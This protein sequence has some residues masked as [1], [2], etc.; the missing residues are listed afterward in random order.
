MKGIVT[1]VTLAFA[2]TVAAC[3]PMAS[4]EPPM[5]SLAAPPTPPPQTYVIT[6]GDSLAIKFYKN[7]ELN[8]DAIVRPDG[9]IS[10]QL[11]DDVPAA[12]R[13]TAQLAADLKQRYA[14]ELAD[15]AIAVIVRNLVGNRVYIGGEV[16]KQGSIPLV[17]G[18]TVFQAIQEAGGFARTAHR[19]QV[20]LIR[21]TPDGKATGRAIDVRPRPTAD[22]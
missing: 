21:R 5:P 18:M 20:I 3:R 15:P 13:T 1:I 8:E 10:L 14:K 7:P 22:D 9:M 6:I 4:H 17:G 12:G 19:K 16:G 11:V 2:L